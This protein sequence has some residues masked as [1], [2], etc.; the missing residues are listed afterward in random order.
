MCL[1]YSASDRI[2]LSEVNYISWSSLHYLCVIQSITI[3]KHLSTHLGAWC[4]FLF[5]YVLVS[6]IYIWSTSIPWVL[7]HN[8][9]FFFLK[10]WLLVFIPH[11]NTIGHSF[12]LK[13]MW[14]IV[15][16]LDTNAISR[17]FNW[18]DKRLIVVFQKIYE[19]VTI[20]HIF[21]RD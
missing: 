13:N 16:C 17:V 1:L 2:L 12:L 19:N 21:S 6:C 14:S 7:K 10:T 8:W 5:A 18:R 20:D 9:S 15:Y 3:E 4:C 11:L